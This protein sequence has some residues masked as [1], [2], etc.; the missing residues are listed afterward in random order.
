MSSLGKKLIRSLKYATGKKLNLMDRIQEWWY[1]LWRYTWGFSHLRDFKYVIKHLLSRHDLIRTGLGKTKYYDKPE[2]ILYGMMNLLVDFVEKEK[3]FENVD[4]SQGP[5]WK[6]IG[7]SIQEIYDWWKD[8]PNRQNE[9]S[10]ALDNWHDIKFKDDQPDEWLAK[11]NSADTIE[12]E[13]YSKIHDQ[14]EK[15][16]EDEETE[17]L[18]K[19]MKIRQGLWV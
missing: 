13:R 11:I 1:N 4:Y 16:L 2:L 6:D 8:Y 17:M 12:V 5:Y 7:D 3:C 18:I 9:I 19:L 14:L 10:I 15:R